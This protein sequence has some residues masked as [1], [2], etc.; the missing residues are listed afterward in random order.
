MMPQQAAMSSEPE[1]G[2][3]H[4]LLVRVKTVI[5]EFDRGRAALQGGGFTAA[6]RLRAACVVGHTGQGQL[7][8]LAASPAIINSRPSSKQRSGSQSAIISTAAA[9]NADGVPCGI[10]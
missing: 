6:V 3:S 9:A 5:T 4:R 8:L 7:P 2:G 10:A 1:P